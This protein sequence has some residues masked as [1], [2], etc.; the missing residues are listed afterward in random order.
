METIFK[1]DENL[2]FCCGSCIRA[3]PV[4]MSES[5]I[6]INETNLVKDD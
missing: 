4:I 6:C 3:C 1:A 5:I 2:C